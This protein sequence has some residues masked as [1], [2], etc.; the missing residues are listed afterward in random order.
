MDI[1]S[2]LYWI[3]ILASLCIYSYTLIV[4]LQNSIKY[5]FHKE[6]TITLIIA[7]VASLL[8]LPG[9]FS[10]SGS[11]RERCLFFGL[12]TLEVAALSFNIYADR[13]KN[14]E[15]SINSII[16]IVISYA[17]IFSIFFPKFFN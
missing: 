12:L 15:L 8:K 13:K 5:S 7:C 4:G 1:Y 10:K 6:L 17:I 3:G 14:K 11:L 16:F 2:I 9:S